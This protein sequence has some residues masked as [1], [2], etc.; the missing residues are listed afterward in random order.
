MLTLLQVEAFNVST[1]VKRGAGAWLGLEALKACFRNATLCARRVASRLY[2]SL[3]FARY[4]LKHVIALMDLHSCDK[5]ARRLEVYDHWCGMSCAVDPTL[6][7]L[8]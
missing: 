4:A 2:Y 8:T 1:Q 7:C 3:S 5:A 6:L